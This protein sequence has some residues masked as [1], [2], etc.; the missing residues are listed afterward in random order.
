MKKSILIINSSFGKHPFLIDSARELSP[1]GFNFQLW[2]SEAELLDDFRENRWHGKKIYLGPGVLSGFGRFLFAC[3]YLP[4]LFWNFFQIFAIKRK[5][6][7][8][9]IVCLDWNEKILFAPLAKIF[10]LKNIWLERPEINYRNLPSCLLRVYR[11]FSK[12]AKLLVFVK[13]NCL[14]LEALGFASENIFHLHPGVKIKKDGGHQ[15]SIFSELA[16]SERSSFNRKYFTLGVVTDYL[17]PNQIESLL[18]AV[19]ICQSVVSNIQLVIVGE[20]EA[21][22]QTAWT[23]KKMEIE[24]LV[25]LVG[26]Q[27]NLKKWFDSFDIYVSVSEALKLSDIKLMLKAMAYELPILGFRDLGM[28]DFVYENENGFLS[29]P[30]DSEALAQNILKFYKNK[31][32]LTKLGRQGKDIVE[33]SFNIE[34][35]AKKFTELL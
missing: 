17:A 1:Q 18:Q 35:Q 11:F 28:E 16:K 7:V 30:G 22:K 23:A 3:L 21:K 19:K 6:G 15:D 14:L 34:K 29:N 12:R 25:W 4:L 31:L 10:K 13:K 9:A 24:N 26:R 2:S 33:T 5:H 27:T 20:G 32:S 8:S